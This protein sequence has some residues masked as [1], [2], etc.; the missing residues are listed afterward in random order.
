MLTNI[1]RNLKIRSL[2]RRRIKVK[3]KLDRENSGSEHWQ[4]GIRD[5]SHAR[6]DAEYLDA[7]AK[8]HAWEPAYWTATKKPFINLY[9]A[10]Q[11]SSLRRMERKFVATVRRDTSYD[12]VDR[13]LITHYND[14]YV[15][16]YNRPVAQ[17]HDDD[18]AE[19]VRLM[20]LRYDT[21][22]ERYKKL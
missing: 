7:K 10:Y 16:G 2:D 13:K 1:L 15:L 19:Q 18:L 5:S 3:K 17:C 12:I 4:N 6:I 8:I 9:H 22:M 21:L 20:Y 14:E 11:R